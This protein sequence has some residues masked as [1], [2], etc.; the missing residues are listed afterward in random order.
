MENSYE[1]HHNNEQVVEQD[2][3]AL[4]KCIEQL[5]TEQKKCVSLFYLQEKS[6]KEV[7]DLTGYTIKQV[8]SFIQNG[9]RNLKINLLRLGCFTDIFVILL[10]IS[11]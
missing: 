10:L 5:K 9:K 3:E 1:L 6:Y 2:L 4:K 11:L 7:S 8:K